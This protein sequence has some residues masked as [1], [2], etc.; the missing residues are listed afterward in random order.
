MYYKDFN[1]NFW[2]GCYH[3][4]NGA[5]RFTSTREADIFVLIDN[6]GNN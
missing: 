6:Y 1:I 3:A 4:D 5:K 2:A